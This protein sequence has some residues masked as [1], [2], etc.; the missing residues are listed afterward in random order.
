MKITVEPK[1]KS[2]SGKV[3]TGVSELSLGATG[4]RIVVAATDETNEKRTLI[5]IHFEEARGFRVLDEGD[6]IPYW[7]S[8]V[9]EPGYCLFEI[10]SGGWLEQERQFPG[11]LAITEAVGDFR[12]W[13]ICTEY[14]CVNVL[15]VNPPLIREFS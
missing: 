1:S 9:F 6:L 2:Y 8:K 12:E 4:L 3:F 15:A 13:F 10:K 14:N 7:Q 5:E 11:M